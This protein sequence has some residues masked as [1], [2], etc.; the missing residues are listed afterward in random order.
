[1][2]FSQNTKWITMPPAYVPAPVFKKEFA[3]GGPVLKAL[4]TV[5]GLGHM[6]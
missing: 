1:M 2:E 6:F 5:I 4:C 3:V